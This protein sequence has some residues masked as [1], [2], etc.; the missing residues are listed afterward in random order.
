MDFV[1]AHE[2]VTPRRAGTDGVVFAAAY[3]ESGKR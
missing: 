1:L 3:A 2:E